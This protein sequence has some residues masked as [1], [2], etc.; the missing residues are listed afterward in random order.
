MCRRWVVG[1]TLALALALLL[2]PLAAG[3]PTLKADDAQ[4]PAATKSDD[5][6]DAARPRTSRGQACVQGC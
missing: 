4:A 6:C 1:L 2:P 5:A 3:A